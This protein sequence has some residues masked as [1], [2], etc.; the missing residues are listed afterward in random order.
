[1]NLRH[2]A[3]GPILLFLV[4]ACSGAGSTIAPTASPSS[5]P[6]AASA[7]SRP[8]AITVK[9]TDS[10][11]MEPSQLTVKAGEAIRFVVTNAG[12]IDHEFYLGD[13]VA[14]GAHEQ[15]MMSMGGTMLHD[16]ADGIV[17][18][19]GETKELV[20]TFSAAGQFLAG[21]HVTGHYGAGMKAMIT[22]TG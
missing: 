17:L 12:A 3:L 9:L 20:H 8:E 1:M 10:L 22:V 18:K 15:E 14:Q 13:E 5:P 6:P 2:F 4:A 16:E 19:P 11:R 21:C 7:S